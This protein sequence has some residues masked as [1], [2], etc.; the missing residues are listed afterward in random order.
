MKLEIIS[1]LPAGEQH[2]TPLLFIHGMLH[3]AWCW[4][5]HFLNYFAQHGFASYAVNLRGH[6]NSEGQKKLRWAS[7]ADF[8]EDV[9]N[10]VRQL[11]RSPILIGHSMGG[12]VIQKYLENHDAP[13]AVLL[14]SP[15]PTGL[16]PTVFRI[17]KR[18]PLAFAKVN[19]TFTI[20]PIISTPQLAREAFFSFN[21][22]DDELLGYWKLMQNESY[23]ALLDMVLFNRPKPALVKTPLLVL[24]AGRD[25]MLRPREIVAT[26]RS[27]KTKAEI[28]TGVA[29][30]SM[31]EQ[32]W[33]NVASRILAWVKKT[34]S[35]KTR[36]ANPGSMAV[37]GQLLSSTAN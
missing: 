15:P 29:H 35:V 18:H 22:P 13:G 37:T 32:N 10:T 27:Y 3:A 11:P 17:A 7:I 30:N 31:L 20:K 6:G 19:L 8:V 26:A 1:K 4:D 2:P 14:S 12:F 25:N 24:G 28:I 23:R 36:S 5:V 34:E 9:E 16:L 21:F 33:E